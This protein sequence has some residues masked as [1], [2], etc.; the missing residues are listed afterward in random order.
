MRIRVRREAS[1]VMDKIHNVE[2]DH[3]GRH[4]SP[5]RTGNPWRRRNARRIQHRSCSEMSKQLHAPTIA[6]CLL[7]LYAFAQ[8]HDLGTNRGFGNEQYQF[9]P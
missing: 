2:G 4:Q 3:V 1:G 6:A 8:D 5:H 9:A 7:H